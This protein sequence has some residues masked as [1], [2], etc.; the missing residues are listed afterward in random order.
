MMDASCRSVRRLIARGPVCIVEE[1][2]CGVL[3]VSVGVLT[4]RLQ[5]EVVA[6]IWETLGEALQQRSG[7]HAEASSTTMP[8]L[9]SLLPKER[10]S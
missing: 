9:P 3:H 8:L 6:S 2:T 4:L 1:C 7:R 10:P 5:K